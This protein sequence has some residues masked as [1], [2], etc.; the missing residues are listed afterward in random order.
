MSRRPV[1]ASHPRRGTTY[2]FVLG[3][4]M[5]I[6]VLGMGALT[7]SRVASRQAVDGNDWET[8]GTLAFSATEHAL[9]SLNAAAAASPGAWRTSYTS[10]QTAFTQVLG[11]GR[12]SWAIKDEVDGNLG[13]DYLQSFRVYGIGKVGAV[14][15]VY[16]VQVGPSGS[17]LDVL[18]TA[19]HS[20]VSVSLTGKTMNNYGPISSNGQV[21]LSGTVYGAVEAAS[22]SGSASGATAVTAPSPAKTMPSATI[23]DALAADATEIDYDTIGS[24][25]DKVLLSPTSNPW[26]TPNAKGLYLVTVPSNKK[27]Q[28]TKSRIVGTLLVRGAKTVDVN[29]PVVWETGP[30][31]GPLLVVSSP[32][33]DVKITGFD[34][35]LDE[36]DVGLNLN[37][38]ATP[39]ELASNAVATDHFPPQYCGIIHCMVGSG[40][41]LELADNVHISGTVIADCPVTTKTM[42]T[43]LQ[44]ASIYAS[45][46]FGYAKGDALSAVGGSWRWDT[47]P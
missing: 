5:I 14:T 28:I 2:V 47:L 12:F 11:R 1:S 41:T 29:G 36:A 30:T 34:T 20:S 13:N 33:C 44:D 31:R 17:P 22:T 46:P 43:L 24:K 18:R 23:F 38:P 16:S 9:A 39:F 25:L 19:V 7:L 40:G 21:K 45:P 37:P 4:T 8:A 27:F 15:R 32:G 10:G 6:T 35:W 26:G 3:I 42:A